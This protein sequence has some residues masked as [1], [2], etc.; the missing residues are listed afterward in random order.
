MSGQHNNTRQ[1]ILEPTVH[2]IKPEPK[3]LARK[4]T[5]RRDQHRK[6]KSHHPKKPSWEGLKPQPSFTVSPEATEGQEN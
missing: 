6:L 3:R 4:S 5:K 1:N 2:G